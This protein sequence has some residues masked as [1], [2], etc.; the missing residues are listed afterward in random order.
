MNKNLFKFILINAV[1]FF[2][3]AFI[4]TSITLNEKCG[5]SIPK[6]GHTF[7]GYAKYGSSIKASQTVTATLDG[8]DFSTT[9]DSSGFYY[10]LTPSK[11]GNSTATTITFTVCT[12]TASE[13]ANFS[14]GAVNTNFNLTI[15]SDCPAAAAAAGGGGGGGGAAAGGGGGAAVPS[16]VNL[17]IKADFA[18]TG[19]TLRQTQGDKAKFTV[20]GVQYTA[21][22]TKLTSD[23]I[24]ITVAGQSTVLKIGDS[25]EFD[26]NRDGVNDISVKLIK[27]EGGRAEILYKLLVK[28]EEKPAE[29][30]PPEVKEEEEVKP[31]AEI[32]TPPSKAWIGW[33]VVGVVVVIGL[34]VYFVVAKKK[35]PGLSV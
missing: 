21:E 8:V 24:T 16:V 27:I 6:I 19:T 35:K 17:N 32:I 18:T 11:C 34:V 10:N 25:A 28:A 13:T 23:S 12:R 3:T 22:L 5:G 20:E 9:S 29:E 2:L 26:V 33:L 14:E 15:S 31:P 30:K 7:Q 4:V 1:I